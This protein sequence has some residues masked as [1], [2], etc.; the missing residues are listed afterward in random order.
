MS[1]F[2]DKL[3]IG[4]C[5]KNYFRFYGDLLDITDITIINKNQSSVKWWARRN[6]N[7]LTSACFA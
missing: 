2:S 5:Q 3:V 6:V 1:F 7:A 4:I